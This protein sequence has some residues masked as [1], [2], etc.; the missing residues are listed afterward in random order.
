MTK[1]SATPR[2]NHVVLVHI[3][4]KLFLYNQL[5]QELVEVPVGT[6]LH[7]DGEGFGY[8]STHGCATWC[9]RKFS[10]HAGVDEH[11]AAVLVHKDGTRETMGS[12]QKPLRTG[13]IRF[14]L[15]SLCVAAQLDAAVYLRHQYGAHI[16]ISLESLWILFAADKSSKQSYGKWRAQR[17]STW[18]YFVASLGIPENHLRKAR[19]SESTTQ[20]PSGQEMF[21]FATVS[22]HALMALL[23]R[24]T[25][26][27]KACGRWDAAASQCEVML[28]R[29][30]EFANEARIRVIPD[31]SST[32]VPPFAS[33]GV[34]E[35]CVV[36]LRNGR[37]CGWQAF[38]SQL[39]KRCDDQPSRAALLL[40]LDLDAHCI[41]AE[42]SISLRRAL[43]L[44]CEHKSLSWVLGQNVW[45]LGT[46]WDM[47][48]FDTAFEG[49]W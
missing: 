2:R 25:S 49:E 48:W 47:G 23:L 40:L 3:A 13:R 5:S 32:W 42:D 1:V 9:H 43:A 20:P 36:T 4:S 34:G 35:P 17:W 45:Q 29:A 41:E 27:T 44:C 30:I 21:L 24:W 46:A 10:M 26:C 38:L 19:V 33:T 8:I 12:F 31:P 14:G 16:F 37:L 7:Y 15:G 18:H 39:R 22:C 11:G 28:D 6:T